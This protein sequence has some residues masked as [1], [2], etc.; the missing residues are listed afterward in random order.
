MTDHRRAGPVPRE[1][2]GGGR[3]GEGEEAGEG[4]ERKVE[5]EEGERRGEWG[6]R[7]R[8]GGRKCR[9]EGR[10]DGLAVGE[11]VGVE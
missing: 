4:G 11:G 5:K 1:K 8:G 9:G 6:E 10:E 7:G 3:A 2:K